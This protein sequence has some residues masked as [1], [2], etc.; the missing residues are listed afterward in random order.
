MS[1][2]PGVENVLKYMDTDSNNKK[3]PRDHESNSNN[4]PYMESTMST[5]PKENM[6]RKE[7][8][9]NDILDGFKILNERMNR[10]ERDN[11]TNKQVLGTNTPYDENIHNQQT[12]S[13][14]NPLTMRNTQ[15]GNGANSHPQ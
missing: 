14:L 4:R 15:N 8:L 1:K 6:D 13:S 2:A 10:I 3:R 12:S 7:K 11:V 9:L 5:D